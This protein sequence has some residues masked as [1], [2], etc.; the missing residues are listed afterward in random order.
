VQGQAF[1]TFALASVIWHEMAHG[2][3]KD[4]REARRREEELWTSFVRD[5]RID[6]GTALRYL[7][8]LTRRPDAQTLA[9]R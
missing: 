3:G 5:Q 2:E 6:Q 9:G 1:H 7:D 4:E 8:A